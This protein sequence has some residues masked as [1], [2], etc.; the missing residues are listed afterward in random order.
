MQKSDVVTLFMEEKLVALSV[1]KLES[2]SAFLYLHADTYVGKKTVNEKEIETTLEQE[3]GEVARLS[4]IA[5]IA[6]G[7]NYYHNHQAMNRA[8]LGK[9]VIEKNSK[10]MYM[11]AGKKLLFLNSVA[12]KLYGTGFIS[13]KIDK[14][15][16][17]DMTILTDAFEWC[18][19]HYY[20]CDET[21]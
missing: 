7:I 17:E 4:H 11:R 8:E 5:Y 9:E 13:K 14:N 1:I 3:V 15:S 10:A 21:E 16:V 2:L 18:I 19:R 20:L 12:K 6:D